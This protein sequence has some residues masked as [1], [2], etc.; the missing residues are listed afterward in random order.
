MKFIAPPTFQFDPIYTYIFLALIINTSFTY[1][2]TK[3]AK[4]IENHLYH[5]IQSIW[6]LNMQKS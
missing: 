3:K 4:N 2:M 1:F 6:D 5:P